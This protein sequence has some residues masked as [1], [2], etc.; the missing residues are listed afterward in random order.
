MITFINNDKNFI[1]MQM[2]EEKYNEALSCNQELIQAASVAS[3]SSSSNEVDSRFVNIKYIKDNNI[4][5]FTNYNSPKSKQF[6]EHDQV[7]L[8]LFWSKINVQIRIQ[9]KIKKT[10]RKYNIDYFKK[11]ESQKNVLAIASD[12]SKEISSYKAMLEKYDTTL[13]D[14]NSY[15]CPEYWGGFIIEPYKYEFWK[16]HKNRLNYREEFKLIENKWHQRILQP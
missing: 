12:Q 2:L 16:G 11:R 4:I 10:S 9:G 15:E 14:L 8:T 3:F 6:I 5:F 13:M 1:P 7:A